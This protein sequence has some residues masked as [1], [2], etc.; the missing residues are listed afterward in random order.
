M[1]EAEQFRK[2]RRRYSV[3]EKIAYLRNFEAGLI[4]GFVDSMHEFAVYYHIPVLTFKKWN[5]DDLEE[6][7]SH[8]R[9]DQRSVKERDVGLWLIGLH[10]SRE[11]R[12]N[13][14]RKEMDLIS[15]TLTMKN[16]LS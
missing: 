4:D 1:A 5:L 2:R 7:E 3:A 6:A 16:S 12:K 9:G 15:R 11:D 10:T 14:M 13:L 8:G